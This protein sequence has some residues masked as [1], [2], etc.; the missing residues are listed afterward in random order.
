MPFRACAVRTDAGA[1]CDDV[2]FALF[3]SRNLLHA[4]LTITHGTIFSSQNVLH[5]TPP[6]NRKATSRRIT[7]AASLYLSLSCIINLQNQT[8][9]TLRRMWSICVCCL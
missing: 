5:S 3:F 8:Q 2:S 7:K 4:T 9:S 6:H 1:S